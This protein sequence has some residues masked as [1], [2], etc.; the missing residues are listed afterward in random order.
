MILI[1]GLCFLFLVLSALGIGTKG[2]WAFSQPVSQKSGYCSR[3][4]TASING[5]FLTTVFMTHLIQYMPESIYDSLDFMYIE[6]NRA[7]GQ[8]IVAM[9]LFYS[10]YGVMESLRHKKG[11]ISSFP[12]RRLLPFFVNFEIAAV[13]YLFVSCATNQTPT[14][15]Y[16][17]KGF[18]AWESLGNSNWYVFAILYLYVVTYIVFRI[19]ETKWFCKMPLW[20]AVFGIVFLSGIYIL[21]MRH[22]GKGGWWYDTILCYSAG[23]FFA[24]GRETFEKWLSRKRSHLRYLLCLIGTAAV[25]SIFYA[26]RTDH[27]LYFEI[28][29]VSFAMLVVLLSMRLRAYN[30][31]YTYIGQNL[32]SFYIYQRI[33]MILLKDSLGKGNAVV[34][35]LVCAVLT[36]GISLLMIRF[37]RRLKKYLP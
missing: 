24:L 3:E 31:V 1:F 30:R 7:L 25:F 18:I 32:F 16:A 27:K 28:I 19:R 26:M 37:Y 23:M 4:M 11:Y 20:F 8:L 6:V 21:W 5:Y 17:L 22:A 29:S 10:G 15:W 36:A 14:F 13:I 12:K 9:F 33:P 2:K 35:L 34:Y